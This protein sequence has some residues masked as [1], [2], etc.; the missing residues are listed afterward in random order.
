M[1]GH[2]HPP[3]TKPFNLTP[4]KGRPRR[5][6]EPHRILPVSS[7]YPHRRF[8]CATHCGQFTYANLPLQPPPKPAQVAVKR[9]LIAVFP[10]HQAP[11]DPGNH[12]TRPRADPPTANSKRFELDTAGKGMPAGWGRGAHGR[13]CLNRLHPLHPA[14]HMRLPCQEQTSR[15]SPKNGAL[16]HKCL[17]PNISYL[18]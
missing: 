14:A 9:S 6:R 5:T 10:S 17:N 18:G 8:I 15:M 4:P 7:P 13:F 3:G 16:F 1:P 11:P 12:T 2:A